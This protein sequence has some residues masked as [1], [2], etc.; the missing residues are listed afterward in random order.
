VH[1]SAA[2]AQGIL[3]EPFRIGANSF[4]D[5]NERILRMPVLCAILDSAPLPTVAR[6]SE[7]L[8]SC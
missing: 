7:K 2:D 1:L 5:D 3:E 4:A 6:V 8:K